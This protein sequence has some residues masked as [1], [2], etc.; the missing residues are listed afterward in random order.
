MGKASHPH[1]HEH[2]QWLP[3]NISQHTEPITMGHRVTEEFD[4]TLVTSEHEDVYTITTT[5]PSQGP[6]AS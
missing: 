3:A 1:S 5:K 6:T 2:S 4:S